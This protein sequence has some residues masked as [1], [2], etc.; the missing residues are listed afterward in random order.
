ME[1]YE[2]R[3]QADGEPPADSEIDMMLEENQYGDILRAVLEWKG[4]VS[5]QYFERFHDADPDMIKAAAQHWKTWDISLFGMFQRSVCFDR[6]HNTIYH[7]WACPPRSFADHR[8]CV[9][10]R[11]I[12]R[13]HRN[14]KKGGNHSDD[15]FRSPVYVRYISSSHPNLSSGSVLHLV[16]RKY[17]HFSIFFD[18]WFCTD[19]V[20]KNST[21]Y[22]L[23]TKVCEHGV[24]VVPRHSAIRL[25]HIGVISCRCAPCI[26]HDVSDSHWRAHGS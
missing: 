7:S 4:R 24:S 1:A 15:V 25:I 22:K 10:R 20:T 17:S 23:S 11:S 26:L 13:Y 8:H 2:L 21:V 16:T 3:Q 6:D 9:G 18:T 12:S 19:D 5:P 14:P